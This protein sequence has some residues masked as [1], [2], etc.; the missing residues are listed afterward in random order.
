MRNQIIA[1]I[2]DQMGDML[3]FQGENPFKIRAYH[4]AAQ[5]L[6]SLGKDIADYVKKGTLTTLPGIGKELAGKI[7]EFISTG[8]MSAYEELKNSISGGILDMMAIPGLVPKTAKLL[9]DELRVNSIEKLKRYAKRGRLAALPHL[10]EKTQENILKG[11]ELLQKGAERMLLSEALLAAEEMLK[12]L[13]ENRKIAMISLAGSLRRMK[14]TVRDIDIL[15]ASREPQKIMSVFTGMPQVKQVLAHGHTKSSIITKS[16]VQ[17]DLRVVEPD[18]YGA[19]L[20]YFTGSKE[21]NIHMRSI[22]VKKGLKISEYGVFKKNGK[23]RIAGKTEE[24]VYK[25]VGLDFIPPELRE[26]RGEFEA[27]RLKKLPNLITLKDIKGD[28]HVH[29]KWSDGACSIEDIAKR[30]KGLGYEYVAIC[31][32]S[33]SLKVA[34]G[35]SEKDLLKK[36]E[37]IKKVNKKMKGIKVLSGA[38]VDIDSEGKLDYPDNIL[39]ELDIVICA[40]HSGFKQSQDVMTNRILRAMDN[41]YARVF[42]HPTGRLIGQRE[43]YNADLEKVIRH[44][45]KTNTALEINAYPERLDLDDIHAKTAAELGVKMAIATDA[46]TL[47]QL[48]YMRFGVAVARRGWLKKKDVLNTLPLTEL[49]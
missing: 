1:D 15:A 45:K 27:A 6:R 4:R 48:N 11:I 21:H 32:H 46:H 26:D 31:D 2:F 16:G 9:Y 18:S 17:V 5:N 49:L 35:L 36:N 3:E 42:A 13:E 22:A 28:F 30:C 43:P 19:A 29:S 37:Q 24:D 47:D 25:S 38:E 20:V 34:G 40:I 44:A 10:K 33:K 41:K 7:E 39:K 14:E 23:K 8:K 12:T